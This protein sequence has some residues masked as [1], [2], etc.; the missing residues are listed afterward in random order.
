MNG[1]DFFSGW[2]AHY[3]NIIILVVIIVILVVVFLFKFIAV[4]VGFTK[5]ERG[6]A[7]QVIS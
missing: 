7:N 1:K 2:W 4:K 3:K 5:I 6:K